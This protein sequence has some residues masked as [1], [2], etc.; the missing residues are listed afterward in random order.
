MIFTS[1]FFMDDSKKSSFFFYITR[2]KNLTPLANEYDVLNILLKYM[3]PYYKENFSF[4]S[5]SLQKIVSSLK[6]FFTKTLKLI[7]KG[8][9]YL[10][11]YYFKDQKRKMF[12][13]CSNVSEVCTFKLLCEFYDEDFVML[14]KESDMK[15]NNNGLIIGLILY[16][17]I[18]K[19]DPFIQLNNP[20]HIDLLYINV[21]DEHPYRIAS[22]ID[23]LIVFKISEQELYHYASIYE[24]KDY[25]NVYFSFK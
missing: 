22:L 9:S 23:D 2:K 3:M 14:L 21:P 11:R 12:K 4:Q 8:Y 5:F 19:G 1:K 6:K 17:I 24:V 10:D 18:V 15:I 16:K 13:D 7:T 25:K 20:D